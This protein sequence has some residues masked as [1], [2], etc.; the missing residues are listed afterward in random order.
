MSTTKM[1]ALDEI[2]VFGLDED[3]K[4]KD[5]FERMNSATSIVDA[6]ADGKALRV[7]FRE[8]APDHD[9][10]K[11]YASDMKKIVGW[12]NI[13]KDLPLFSEPEKIAEPIAEEAPAEEVEVPV[14]EEKPKAKKAPAKAAP[15]GKA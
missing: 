3:I 2:T 14:K 11:V 13:L 15:K 10:E 7:F 4:L 5:I 8:V 1:A 9:E 6:K 12:Y